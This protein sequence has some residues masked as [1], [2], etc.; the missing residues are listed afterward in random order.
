MTHYYKGYE[1]EKNGTKKYP[2]NIYKVEY[3]KALNREY[4][5]NVGFERTF[6][7]CKE[8]IDNGLV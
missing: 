4:R 1:I 6:K 3:S 2:W 5:V 7:L 8:C